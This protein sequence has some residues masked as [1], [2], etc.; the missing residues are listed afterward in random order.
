M[1]ELEKALITIKDTCTN[2]AT[3]REC[4]LRRGS[5]TI[6]E[7]GESICELRRCDPQ[8][9]NLKIENN[10]EPEVPRLFV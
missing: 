8:G 2:H 4:P 5:S 10:V 7:S 3:C 6:L 1:T 9:W